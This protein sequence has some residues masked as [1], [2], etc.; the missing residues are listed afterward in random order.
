MTDLKKK[1]KSI[2]KDK[3][4]NKDK[5]LISKVSSNKIIQKSSLLEKDLKESSVIKDRV[6]RKLQPIQ[7]RSVLLYP[8][9]PLPGQALQGSAVKKQKGGQNIVQGIINLVDAFEVLGTSI[10]SEI[11][12]LMNT[13]K[14]MMASSEPPP[15]APNY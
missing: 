15:G 10:G 5:L 1:D 8:A 12:L 14:D 6:F 9:S 11:T 3:L 13:R 7:N 4:K 2:N